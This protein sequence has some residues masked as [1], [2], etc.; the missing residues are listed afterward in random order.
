MTDYNSISIP[1]S[2]H[3][4]AV[5]VEADEEEPVFDSTN[6]TQPKNKK[7]KRS[8]LLQITNGG[9]AVTV[10][11]F[12]LVVV[13]ISVSVTRSTAATTEISVT[14]VMATAGKKPVPCTFQECYGSSCNH[15][16]APYTCLFNNG[17]PHG[18]C[19]PT[20]WIKGT[21]TTQCDLTDCASLSIP[22][23]TASCD[24]P[25]DD[26]T[27]C[28][29]FGARLCPT[30]TPFQCTAGSAKFGCSSEKFEWSLRTSDA[31]CSACCHTQS[32]K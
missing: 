5:L 16:V 26:K 22:D 4:P 6:M 15:L 10:L 24:S 30:L 1:S 23:D 12:M 28:Q 27:V 29:I 8:S 3:H 17:G 21:C 9:M 32:C 13:A 11:F 19:S 7:S 31:T 14:T 20:P 18:G 2:H 25:C